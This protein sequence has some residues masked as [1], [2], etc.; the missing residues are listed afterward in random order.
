MKTPKDT[1]EQLPDAACSAWW[2][3][4]KSEQRRRVKQTQPWNTYPLGTKA[5]A[6]GGGS[7]TR[8]EH[9]WKWGSLTGGGGTFP[10]PGGDNDGTVIMPNASDQATA[11]EKLP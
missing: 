4:Y 5:P 6:I 1:I 11:S 7:W 9:G 2:E 3:N 10:T 8:V